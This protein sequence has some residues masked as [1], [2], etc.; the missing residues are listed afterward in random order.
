[1]DLREDPPLMEKDLQP[2]PII[3]KVVGPIKSYIRRPPHGEKER[4]LRHQTYDLI[5]E[6]KQ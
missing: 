6:N 4:H 5:R 2:I 1:M 3:S